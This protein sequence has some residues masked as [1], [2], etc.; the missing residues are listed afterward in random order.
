MG[1]LDGPTLTQFGASR[2]IN[3]AEKAYSTSKMEE[4][5]NPY[6]DEVLISIA[7]SAAYVEASLNEMVE[8]YRGY[9]RTEIEKIDDMKNLSLI[10]TMFRRSSIEIR[11]KLLVMALIGQNFNPDSP[12]FRDLKYLFELRNRI[13]HA[14]PIKSDIKGNVEPNC[15]QKLIEH[16]ET[17]GVLQ[18]LSKGERLAWID[19]LR[20]PKVA[21]WAIET[22]KSIHKY[23]IG[24]FPSSRTK[25]TLEEMFAFQEKEFE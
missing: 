20:T 25:E 5:K 6:P 10:W 18:P 9:E 7:F 14:E 15:C 3:I 19:R 22:S 24:L 13:I 2:L 8:I 23:L 12:E 17:I 4:G 16:L 1:S 11:Y 21:L